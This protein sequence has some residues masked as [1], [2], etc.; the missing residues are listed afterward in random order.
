[1]SSQGS[2]GSNGNGNRYGV[3]LAHD[4]RSFNGPPES[5]SS[6]TQRRPLTVDHGAMVTTDSSSSTASHAPRVSYSSNVN[7]NQISY[8]PPPTNL[9]NHY[10]AGGIN[11]TVNRYG[12]PVVGHPSTPYYLCPTNNEAVA[13]GMPP[14]MDYD[15][16][17]PVGS[18]TDA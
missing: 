11:Y 10:D 7:M 8:M 5:V 14:N 3:D 4:G 13:R 16:K 2:N 12:T 6:S 1:M 17:H 15:K 18:M 9:L